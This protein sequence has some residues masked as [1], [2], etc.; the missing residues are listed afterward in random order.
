M[1]IKTIENE[2]ARVEKK[3]NK[4]EKN[5]YSNE[6]WEQDIRKAYE[7]RDALRRLVNAYK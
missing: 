5:P 7:K 6:T 1:T 3:L 4:L 2:L